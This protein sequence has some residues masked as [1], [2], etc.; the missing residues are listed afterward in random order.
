TRLRWLDDQ[1]YGTWHTLQRAVAARLPRQG[2][3]VFLPGD[4]GVLEPNGP[5][6]E[7]YRESMKAAPQ[8]PA[9]G[10]GERPRA[11]LLTQPWAA[12]GQIDP[13][14]EKQLLGKVL[15]RLRERGFE[16]LVKPHPREPAG[17]YETMFAEQQAPG[18]L[19]PQA[20]TVER[21]FPALGEGDIV[22]GYN[23]TSLLTAALLYGLR[24]YTIGDTQPCREQTGGWYRRT[25]DGFVE[26]AGDSVGDF[27]QEFGEV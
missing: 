17:K 26:L 5:V 21:L 1:L 25:Q 23:S 27:E 24:V 16:V 4:G 8:P 7:D 6:L 22:V 18:E 2:R 13:D 14:A 11:V 20:V 19:L 3:P 15:G 10:S 12:D 9:V